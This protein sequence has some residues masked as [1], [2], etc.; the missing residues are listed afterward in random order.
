MTEADKKIF[1]DVKNL[2]VKI[3]RERIVDNVSFSIKKGEN[4]AII[5][6][7]GAGKT[8]ML[9]AILGNIPHTGEVV[10]HEKP[11]IGYVPQK[12]DFDR[13]IPFTVIE[14][15]LVYSAKNYGLWFPTASVKER[16]KECLRHVK[17]EH[18]FSKNIGTLSRG[19]LQRVLIAQAIFEQPNI[20]ILDEPTASV[21]IEG[22][23][24]IYQLV[25]HLVKEFSLTSVIVS[26]D[27]HIVHDFAD[28][29]ICINKKMLCAGAPRVAMSKD[30]LEELYGGDV[31][32]Y[33]HEHK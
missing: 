28:K 30:M 20:L 24:T 1:V 7:N 18:V 11:V 9:K 26:H 19:E 22:E 29:V 10:W 31:T 25:R 17:A 27:L 21:D 3:G 23:R 32:L 15:F 16:I 14:F 12:F 5:G 4:V 13:T 8:T 6:P 33:T 2:S